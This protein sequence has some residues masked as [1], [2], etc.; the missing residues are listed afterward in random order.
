MLYLVSS[1]K[2]KEYKINSYIEE[3]NKLNQTIK[4]SIDETENLIEYKSTLAYKNKLLK[5]E[6]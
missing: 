6:Q 4:D 1:Y 5:Q 2:Y 3:I